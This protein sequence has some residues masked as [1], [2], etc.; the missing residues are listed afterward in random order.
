MRIMKNLSV[1]LLAK[2]IFLAGDNQVVNNTLMERHL[3][4]LREEFLDHPK[5]DWI[6]D[7]K[8]F[9]QHKRFNLN[10]HGALH[11]ARFDI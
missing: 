10:L 3:P 9:T 8:L 1:G 11:V 2:G 6:Q 4:E 5:A 7:L